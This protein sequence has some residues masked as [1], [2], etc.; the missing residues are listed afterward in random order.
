MNRIL[1]V[2]RIVSG[3]IIL[4][5]MT[6]CLALPASAFPDIATTRSVD[7]LEI[8]YEFHG[9]GSPALVFVHGWCCD[10][11]YWRE[12]IDSFAKTH[13]VVAIDLGGHGSSAK[14]RERW[15][16]DLFAEDVK[17]V[18]EKLGLDNVILVGHSMGGP[19]VAGAS[20]KLG[21]KV[22][23]IVGVDTYQN[24]GTK[25]TDAQTERFLQGFKSDFSSRTKMMVSSMFAPESDPD[26]VAKIIT[27]M[28]SASPE[29][30]IGALESTLAY[31]PKESLQG[32]KAPVIAINSD[33]YPT[34][35]EAGKA[36][37]LSFD[38][39]IIKGCGHFLML[40]VPE[41]F[42]SALREAIEELTSK[43]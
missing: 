25:Y 12:Q 29:V 9:K 1:H 10:R 35:I 32:L 4:N 18:V 5:V 21:D 27:D 22:I 33:K 30:G 2:S 13:L 38:V 7:G 41:K 3:I 14:G 23:G 28:S 16:L 37:I 36:R 42:N 43:E 8:T 39:K 24:L 34:N 20:M 26:F 6:A 19:V 15:T 17:A 40:E 31:D 11:S